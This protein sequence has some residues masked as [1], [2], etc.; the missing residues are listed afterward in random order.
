M[1]AARAGLSAVGRE[2]GDSKTLQKL[3]GPPLSEG[4]FSDIRTRGAKKYRMQFAPFAP[5]TRARGFL[6]TGLI[7]ERRN[8]YRRSRR[9]AK[10]YYLAS[11]KPEFQAKRVLAHF[12]LDSF[13]AGVAGGDD[14]RDGGDKEKSWRG[15]SRHMRSMY[16]ALLWSEIAPTMCARHAAWVCRVS[17]WTTATE[18]GENWKRPAQAIL[19]LRYILCRNSSCEG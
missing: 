15:L 10:N 7:P 5:I 19:F 17:V 9:A 8:C 14:S 6:K 16:E 13:F 2:A 18:A 4:F 12:S 11:S 1:N 3:I